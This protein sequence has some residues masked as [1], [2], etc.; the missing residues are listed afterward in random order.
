MSTWQERRDAFTNS[1]VKSFERRE[2]LSQG[3]RNLL[4]WG[5]E[6]GWNACREDEGVKKLVGALEWYDNV[7]RNHWAIDLNDLVRV[8]QKALADFKGGGE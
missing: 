5:C 3:E 6:Y 4:G 8:A 7:H 2:K 1:K